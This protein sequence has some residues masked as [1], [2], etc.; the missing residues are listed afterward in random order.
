[1]LKALR[2]SHQKEEPNDIFIMTSPSKLKQPN[3]SLSHRLCL[4]L[5]NNQDG[6]SNNG[7]NKNRLYSLTVVLAAIL[8][9]FHSMSP[10]SSSSDYTTPSSSS[11][12]GL[13]RTFSSSNNNNKNE[14]TDETNRFSY[15][16]S[17]S[18]YEQIWINSHLP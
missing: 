4:S 7:T 2:L 16:D 12:M 6:G 15:T 5:N 1:M 14:R 10:S 13:L 18:P 8:F 9:F 3:S 11:S 17:N